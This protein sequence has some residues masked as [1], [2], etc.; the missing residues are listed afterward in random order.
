MKLEDLFPFLNPEEAG[1]LAGFLEP[2]EVKAGEDIF[3]WGQPAVFMVFIARGR[4]VV[5]K[6]TEFPGKDQVIAVLETGSFAGEAGILDDSVHG[7]TVTAVQDSELLSLKRTSFAALVR[8]HPG[9][10]ID[11]L[12][13]LLAIVHLRLQKTSHRLSMVL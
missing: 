2:L 7:A 3:I 12:R 9:L 13:Y 11:L 4:L 1:I 5:K 10:A 8:S 6:P